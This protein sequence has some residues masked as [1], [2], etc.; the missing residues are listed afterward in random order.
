MAVG[1][2][3]SKRKASQSPLPSYGQ[4]SSSSNTHGNVV[5]VTLPQKH[6]Y[7]RVSHRSSLAAHAKPSRSSSV[8]FPVAFDSGGESSGSSLTCHSYKRHSRQQP[9]RLCVSSSPAEPCLAVGSLATADL[10]PAWT[11]PLAWR[12]EGRY[13]PVEGSPRLSSSVFSTGVR[14]VHNT[15]SGLQFIRKRIEYDGGQPSPQQLL[16]VKLLCKLRSF[17]YV[18]EVLDI[19]HAPGRI[20]LILPVYWGTLVD[21]LRLNVGT[22]VLSHAKD[23]AEQ[24]LA[25]LSHLHRSGFV[26]LDIQPSS[27]CI[28]ADSVLKIGDFKR[29]R[30]VGAGDI[31]I[32]CGAPGYSAPEAIIG[33]KSPTFQ[34]DVWS[35]GCV[36]AE[37]FGCPPLFRSEGYH[38]AIDSILNFT[39]HPGGA[40]FPRARGYKVDIFEAPMNHKARK[41]TGADQLS[42]INPS[43]AEM[44]LNMLQLNPN[45]RPI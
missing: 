29:M 31:K 28:T 10:P 41:A 26:H 24:L 22:R 8:T 2:S 21:L 6:A 5:R 32:I 42:D 43:A 30:R 36:L 35:A 4:P 18:T 15:L 17:D 37:I 44:I 40:V 1:M 39:G 3:R 9:E 33:S 16:H 12:G 25:G 38:E 34:E 7:E 45:R 13:V 23:L 19:I 20:D 27:I 14:R 11:P